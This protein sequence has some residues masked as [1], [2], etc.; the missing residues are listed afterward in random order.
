MPSPSNPPSIH[1]PQQQ[2]F[3]SANAPF[4]PSTQSTKP[5]LP[6]GLGPVVALFL[7]P[8]KPKP[9]DPAPTMV[10]PPKPHVLFDNSATPPRPTSPPPRTSLPKPPLVLFNRFVALTSST[11]TH[12]PLIAS[13]DAD[14]VLRIRRGRMPLTDEPDRA[15]ADIT[16]LPVAYAQ[17]VVLVTLK[18][19]HARRRPNRFMAAFGEMFHA[20]RSTEKASSHLP[21]PPS[22]PPT[23]P[24]AE[25]PTQPPS[26]RRSLALRHRSSPNLAYS[27][28]RDRSGSPGAPAAKPHDP[29]DLSAA[30]RDA[31]VEFRVVSPAGAFGARAETVAAYQVLRGIVER[32][33]GKALAG[34]GAG[35]GGDGCGEGTRGREVLRGLREADESNGAC[36]RCGEEDPEWVAIEREKVVAMI[37]CEACS[38]FFRSKPDFMVRSFLY[39]ISLFEDTTS[40]YHTA[41]TTA[42]NMSALLRLY[43]DTTPD[44][45]MEGVMRP[46]PPPQGSPK[47][48]PAMPVL[49]ASG[50]GRSMS[51]GGLPVFR[52]TP[53]ARPASRGAAFAYAQPLAGGDAPP[54]GGPPAMERRGVVPRKPSKLSITTGM[55]VEEE[56]EEEEEVVVVVPP[57]TMMRRRRSSVHTSTPTLPMGPGVERGAVVPEQQR[58]EFLGRLRSFVEGWR[59]KGK[60]G[61]GGG[62]QCEGVEGVE[63]GVEGR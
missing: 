46:P 47:L 39:D 30:L 50:H 52:K 29:S 9:T 16:A 18:V 11:P 21:S 27:A 31:R 3:K 20:P 7:S 2:H 43:P 26:G 1:S 33:R 59:G 32:E 10:V 49:G 12:E 5:R 62:V 6:A 8:P 14:A 54:E 23:A 56:E 45:A 36:A 4:T 60:G 58:S 24:A 35:G 63:G 48:P 25:P 17:P 51:V 19:R 34:C 41:V 37:V 38:G 57:E 13:V 15:A 44:D 28:A 22:S 61:R 55:S 42:S 53:P 40:P